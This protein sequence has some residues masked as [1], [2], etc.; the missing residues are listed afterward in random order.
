MRNVRLTVSYDGSAYFGFQSQPGKDTIQA[1]LQSAL[2]A[3]TGV[4]TTVIA[5]GR[6]DAGVHARA[7]VVNFITGSSIPAG[8][9]CRALN[10][11]LPPD[12]VVWRAEDVPLEFHAR[13]SAKRKT[14][15]Y[16]INGNRYADVFSKH[17]Q[18][19]HPGPLNVQAMK[20]A[21]PAVV[22]EHDFT[23]FCSMRT[24]CE[25]RIRTI[26]EARLEQEEVPGMNNV[27]GTG[28]LRVFLTGNGFLYHMVRI[29]T[30]TL[31]SIGEGKLSS[32]DMRRI[33]EARDRTQAGPTAK[34]QGL[35][36]WEVRYDD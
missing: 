36:L 24:G 4:E 22:G 14:Y 19:H 9:W 30:G 28:V 11:Y 33:L 32:S 10:S 17:T 2:R 35:T 12:I 16:A 20:D 7:Q 31:I 21:L 18:Y 23:S 3:V 34:A 26:Y 5:S 29:I 13:K 27:P 25:S 6:T 1:R 8:R 15:C